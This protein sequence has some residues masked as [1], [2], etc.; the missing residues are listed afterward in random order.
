MMWQVAVLGA[1]SDRP[2]GEAKK[3]KK[4]Q[5]RMSEESDGK[6]VYCRTCE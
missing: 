5:K 2:N 3:K 1:D 6:M 4:V